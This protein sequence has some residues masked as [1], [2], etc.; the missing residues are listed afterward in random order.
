MNKK[1]I[2]TIITLFIVWKLVEL[3]FASLGKLLFPLQTDFLGGGLLNY[4]RQ[5]F[6]WSAINFDG[7]HYL[8][9]AREGYLPLTY[10]YFPLYP[11]IIRSFSLAIGGSYIS[12]AVSG[13][14]ISNILLL[15]GLFGLYKLGQMFFDT[16]QVMLSIVLILVFP[17][18]FFL[19]AYYNETLFFAL[20]VWSFYFSLKR[21]WL[22]SF[23]LCG[24]ATATRLVGVAL[25]ISLIYEYLIENKK[26]IITL[27]SFLYSALPVFGIVCYSTYLQISTGDFLAFI[28]NIEIFGGQRTSKIVLLPQVFYRY[29]FK[30]IPA[31]NYSYFPQVYVTFL[32][33]AVALLFLLAGY[34]VYKK[35]KMSFFIFYILAY[36][37]PTFSGSFSSLP[38]YVLVIFPVFLV[39]GY[40]IS[41]VRNKSIRYLIFSLLLLSN[42]LAQAL[43]VRGYFVS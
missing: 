24:M 16:R 28:H 10:F 13:L 23:A 41:M 8:A 9:I 19:G 42:F 5:P 33:L 20:A 29:F 11:L 27:T 17:T 25:A 18:A 6:F 43:F 15:V 36:L 4:L 21:R 31:V 40:Y 26:K 14:F 32:E 30:I 12:Y 34:F 7:E 39:A 35:M 3:S 1:E 22:F 37:I 38:R 2:T